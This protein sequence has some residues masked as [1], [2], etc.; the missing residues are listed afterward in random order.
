[1]P[2]SYFCGAVKV[3]V[4]LEIIYDGVTEHYYN[5]RSPSNTYVCHRLY[6]ISVCV[7]GRYSNWATDWAVRGWNRRGRGRTFFSSTKHYDQLWFPR[8]FL[9]GMYRS[10][11][12]RVIWPGEWGVQVYTY[13]SLIKCIVRSLSQKRLSNRPTLLFLFEF[14]LIHTV[15]IGMGKDHSVCRK[16]VTDTGC[17]YWWGHSCIRC[18]CFHESPRFVESDPQFN[19][20]NVSEY[21][22]LLEYDAVYFGCSLSIDW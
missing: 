21:L 7:Y 16:V 19:L 12:P 5:F 13:F 1:M 22:F 20:E 10:S 3:R 4:E 2:Y 8:I 15:D 18:I 17:V 6:N 11:S 14:P 9:S